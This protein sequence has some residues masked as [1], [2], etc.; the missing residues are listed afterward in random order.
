VLGFRHFQHRLQKRDSSTVQARRSTP[1]NVTVLVENARI[2]S[3][4]HKN[5]AVQTISSSIVCGRCVNREHVS[6]HRVWYEQW[7]TQAGTVWMSGSTI[8]FAYWPTPGGGR[9]LIYGNSTNF[10][11]LHPDWLGNARIDSDLTNHTVSTDQAYTPYGEIY[12]IFGANVGQ[13]EIFGTMRGLFAFGTTTPVMW[14]TPN[15]ELSVVGRWLSPDPARQ[16]WNAYAYVSN[17]LSFVDP[18]GLDPCP[19][20]SDSWCVEVIDSYLEGGWNAF[21]WYLQSVNGGTISSGTNPGTST[22]PTAANNGNFSWWG[23]FAKNLFSLKNFTAEFKQGGCVNVAVNATAGALNPF[24]PS[25][26]TAGEA[27]AG[28]LA[29]SQYNAAVAYAASAPN[30]LGGTGLIYPMKSSVVRGMIADANATAAEA[31]LFAV[32]G[33]LLQGVIAEGISMAN[34]ECH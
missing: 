17:P 1:K 5:T 33:A 25:L 31:P 26:A 24:S 20:N 27:T 11:Y 32:D 18:T 13:N 28:V 21:S 30:Y 34:G 29:A 8:N 12:D 3:H 16:G 23:A 6:R 2:F 14:D 22:S 4:L 9:V 7:F 15:R 19:A 10:D